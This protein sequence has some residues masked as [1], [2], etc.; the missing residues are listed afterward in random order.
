[1][2][3]CVISWQCVPYVSALVMS[4]PGK[5]VLCQPYFLPITLCT[6]YFSAT[7]PLSNNSAYIRM[8]MVT[9]HYMKLCVRNTTISSTSFSSAQDWTF[10]SSTNDRS[11]FCTW[12]RLKAMSSMY[13]CALILLQNNCLFTHGRQP[14]ISGCHHK[15]EMESG[16]HWFVSLSWKANN[17]PHCRLLSSDDVKWQLVSTSLCWRWSCCFADQLWLLMHVQEEEDPKGL[18]QF[19]R[20]HRIFCISLY[21]CHLLMTFV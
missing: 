5:E 18:E 6:Y 12:L 21:L 4:L 19:A 10:L 8:K 16:S 15:E 13:D 14:S 11:P 3:A 9:Q 17:V 2:H 20:R 1:M 7:V